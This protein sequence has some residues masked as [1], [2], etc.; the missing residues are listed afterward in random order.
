MMTLRWW[1]LLQ[2]STFSPTSTL[3][4]RGVTGARESALG[5]FLLIV[6]SAVV[7]V[8]AILVLVAAL[9]RRR[10]DA[11]PA[12]TSS[13]AELRWIT[14]GG[15]AVPLVILTVAFL[16]TVTTINAVGAPAGPYAATI[17][18]TGHQWWWEV[19]YHGADPSQDVTT[20]NE[21]HVPAGEPVRVELESG[22]VI[23]S[24]W[25][26]ELAGKMDVIPG[27]H[28]AL[29]I[30]AK[31]PGVFTGNCGEYCGP[32]HAHMRL[33]VVADAPDTYRAWLAGQQQPAPTPTATDSVAFNGFATFNRA[34]CSA[35]HGIRGTGAAAAV[36]PDLTHFGS[37]TTL[38]AGLLPNTAA[39]LEAWIAGA[40]QLKPGSDMPD[41]RVAPADLPVLVAYLESL[42]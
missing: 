5:W 13:K 8:I 12:T 34:G 24:F 39:N 31:T 10:A 7:V 6:A 11:A 38:A 40:Q 22:D 16:F 9:R 37:R 18:V 17:Q 25:V 3:S 27:Q 20:A 35:C 29:W 42:R 4:T 14:I 36:G 33:T 26:P 21:I 23:H 30:E 2:T 15:I 28:N 19:R 1:A 32:Q 41:M